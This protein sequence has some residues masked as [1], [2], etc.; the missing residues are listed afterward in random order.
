[1][2][3]RCGWRDRARNDRGEQRCETQSHVRATTCN[4]RVPARKETRYGSDDHVHLVGLPGEHDVCCGTAPAEAL[5]ARPMTRGERE[6]E[7]K[8]ETG[9]A[10]GATAATSESPNR[11]VMSKRRI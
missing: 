7:R 10:I 5:E 3:E 4:R 1:M 9:N 11:I 2:R 8:E 6:R